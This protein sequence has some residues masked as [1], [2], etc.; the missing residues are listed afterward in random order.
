MRIDIVT[1]F[2]DFFREPMEYGIVGRARTAGLVEIRAH[3]LRGWTTDR[4]KIVDDR[5][6]GGGDGMVL[7]PEPIFDA[8]QTLT[9]SS[10]RTKY[11]EGTRVVLLS[12]QGR[13]FNQ[14]VANDLSKTAE[15]LVL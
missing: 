14:S 5:P 9:G 4:H 2:P 10:D 6:F 7:K 11:P 15:H 1:I 12:P 3:D 8:V 13:V